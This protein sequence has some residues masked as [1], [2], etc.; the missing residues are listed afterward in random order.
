M[1]VL[2]R[3]VI[4]TGALHDFVVSFSYKMSNT[5]LYL[6]TARVYM[7]T[8]I[9]LKISLLDLSQKY[10]CVNLVHIKLLCILTGKL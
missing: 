4:L 3:I 10:Y 5:R 2:I 8:N 7:K 6:K 9:P 1:V